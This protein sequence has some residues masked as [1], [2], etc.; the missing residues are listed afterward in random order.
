MS[1]S[2]KFFNVANLTIGVL[3]LLAAIGGAGIAVVQGWTP[4]LV[5][6]NARFSCQNQP[7]TQ[8]GSE[9]WTVMYRHDKG[10]QP[11]LKIVTTLGG[12][13][14]PLKRCEEIASRLEIYR[15][16]GLT[17]LGYRRDPN[18]P[19]QY[20]V[21]AFTRLGRDSCPLLVT[22]KPGSDTE[23]YN[24]MRDMMGNLL[25]GGSGVYQNSDGKLATSQ[26]SPSS[27]E[28]DLTPFL[29]EEDR[30]AGSNSA[31]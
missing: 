19:N 29:A 16:D 30:I 12:G 1:N 18:T 20:V 28:I 22:L 8:R 6:Q 25:N 2:G 13:Y 17:N 3:G 9:V 7:D 15:K 31:K 10:P 14:T 23:A 26:F 24:A 4:L 5:G 11:W 21:C 27:P